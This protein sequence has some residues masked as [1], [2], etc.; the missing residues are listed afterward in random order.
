MLHEEFP[1]VSLHNVRETVPAD[2]TDE[3]YCLHRVPESVGASV[4]VDARERMRHPSGCEL[5]FVPE[6]G[7]I[8][9]T[10]SAA[11]ETVFRVFWGEFQES[12]VYELG[13]RPTI[14]ELSVPPR[15]DVLRPDVAQSGAFDPRVC[16]IRCEAWERVAVHNVRGTCRPPEADE[17]PDRRYLAYG[18]SITE[19]AAASA[20][21]LTYVAR[22]AR[23]LGID[24]L[25]LGAAGAAFCESAIGDHIAERED[26]NLATLSLS[27]NMA[28]RGFTLMQFQERA[29]R[30][31]DRV[32][33]AHPSC[34]VACITLFPYHADAVREDD[35]SRATEFR[36]V[37][38]D[39]VAT[40]PHDNVHLIEGPD[41]MGTNG[42][43]TD[44]LHPGDAGMASIGDG[45][46]DALRPLLD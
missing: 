46:A 33:G 15:I 8:E 29:C 16:R 9:V 1:G 32:A 14:I 44:M 28:N 24:A 39:I 12:E 10:L 43:T 41:L 20:C 4:N 18:T 22:V 23:S 36:D 37:L 19:G 34:P 2:W 6:T 13:P 30:L 21:H 42:L 31:V 40:T 45:L 11:N 25:N 26:W 38:R 3:G 7:S 17:L 5:R 35:L 27:V